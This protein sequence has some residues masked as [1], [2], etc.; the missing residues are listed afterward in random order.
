M[1]DVYG[2]TANSAL[3]FDSVATVSVGCV[4]R[5]EGC[6]EPEAKNFA[7]DANVAADDEVP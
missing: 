4:V 7:A 6:M 2:C 5:V 3:N 1:Y